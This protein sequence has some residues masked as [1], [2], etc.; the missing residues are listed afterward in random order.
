M[1]VCVCIVYVYASCVC[2][3]VCVYTTLRN[4]ERK[5][6]SL[7][8]ELQNTCGCWELNPGPLEEHYILLATELSLQPPG[9][10]AVHYHIHLEMASDDLNSSRALSPLAFP[11]LSSYP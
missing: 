8:L 6:D 4:K 2:V 11:L 5:L 9:I 3:C 1:C 10:I 7:G